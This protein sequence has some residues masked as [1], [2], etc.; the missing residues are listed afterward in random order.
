[1]CSEQSIVCVC[2]CVSVCV[3]VCVFMRFVCVC[4]C[5]RACCCVCVCVCVRACVLVFAPMYVHACLSVCVC[6]WVCVLPPSVYLIID[7]VCRWMKSDWRSVIRRAYHAKSHALCRHVNSTL[8][9]KQTTCLVHVLSAVIKTN[10]H[11]KKIAVHWNM[12]TQGKKTRLVQACELNFNWE[13]NIV[14]RYFQLLL[15]PTPMQWVAWYLIGKQS[16]C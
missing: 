6:V 4:V 1:V 3:S 10:I 2:V 7:V 15:K 11:R 16:S 8:I 12:V 9:A 5:L 14:L 13:T